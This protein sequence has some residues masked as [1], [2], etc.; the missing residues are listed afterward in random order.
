[1]ASWSM[2]EAKEGADPAKALEVYR[3][4]RREVL[5]PDEDCETCPN[6]YQVVK[7]VFPDYPRDSRRVGDRIFVS[8][9]STIRG[10]T[11]Q[12]KV[13]SYMGDGTPSGD[14]NRFRLEKVQYPTAPRLSA[15]STPTS[16]IVSWKEGPVDGRTGV[17]GY[18]LY[19]WKSGDPPAVVPLNGTPLKETGYEDFR[20]ERRVSY[21]YTLRSVVESDGIQV[22]SAPSNEALGSLSEP[23]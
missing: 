10:K 4:L 17:K 19:R 16:I 21:V 2:Q 9:T 5:P 22:E 11:Y 13:V 18:N 6:A 20:L 1:M 12:Y 8:D 7:E 14:S 23:D 15:T 3:L